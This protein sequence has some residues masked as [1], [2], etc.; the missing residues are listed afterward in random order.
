MEDMGILFENQEPLNNQNPMDDS[1]LDDLE[2]SIENPPGFTDPLAEQD[3]QLMD[4]LARQLDAVES[5]IEN[6]PPL[7]P[8]PDL[9]KQEVEPDVYDDEASELEEVP[10]A[11]DYELSEA[12]DTS[13]IA[14]P[15]D[16]QD[17][18]VDKDGIH[19]RLPELPGRRT[20]NVRGRRGLPSRRRFVRP[21]RKTR[22]RKSGHFRFCPESHELIDQQK[23]ES[24]EKYRH[25]PEGTDEEPRQCWFDWHEKKPCEQ[26]DEDDTVP[27][28]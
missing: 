13:E 14:E 3:K 6:A 26:S 28:D 24:C 22:A 10:S 27:E 19:P 1:I 9:I 4:D 20:G 23:C 12:Q 21:I 7:Q 5:S 11:E 17:S 25:W 16:G 18:S 8:E 2:R 15:S